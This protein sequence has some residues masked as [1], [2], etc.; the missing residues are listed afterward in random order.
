MSWMSTHSSY[1]KEIFITVIVYYNINMCIIISIMQH[2][3]CTLL[4]NVYTAMHTYTTYMQFLAA[5][6]L[7]TKRLEERYFIP[8]ATSRHIFISKL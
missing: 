6:S 1:S 4:Y 2:E 7:C 8:L 5:K 3:F